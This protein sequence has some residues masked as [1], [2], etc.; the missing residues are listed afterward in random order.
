MKTSLK[1]NLRMIEFILLFFGLPLF[2]FF[3]SDFIH[4]SIIIAPLLFLIF[5]YLAKT[6]EFSFK[7]LIQIQLKKKALLIHAFIVTLCSIFLFS[8][9]Y[10]FDHENL[11]NLPRSNLLV[12]TILCLMYPLF[13]AYGQEIIYRVFLF[14]RYRTI[15]KTKRMFILASSVSFSF[16]HIVYYSP[17]SII[18]TLFLGIYLSTTYLKTKSV[19]FTSIIHSIFGN[20]IFTIGLGSYFWLDMEK[21]ITQ[22]AFI[23]LAR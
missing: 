6:K 10:F 22:A 5:I 18:L 9:V 8:C 7:E 21:W 1:N 11:F 17:I 13:S 23:I 14:Y 15:F 12:W 3:D 4:P 16:V 19:L 20:L 2:I